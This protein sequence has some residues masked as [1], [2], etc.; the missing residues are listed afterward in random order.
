MSASAFL[1]AARFVIFSA[2]FVKC[3]MRSFAPRA[4]GLQCT[5]PGRRSFPPPPQ[6]PSQLELALAVVGLRALVA[7]VGRRRAVAGHPPLLLG[8]GPAPRGRHPGARAG[9]LAHRLDLLA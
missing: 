7:E 3:D 4:G 9:P 2:H 5:E 8:S 6:N 1:I